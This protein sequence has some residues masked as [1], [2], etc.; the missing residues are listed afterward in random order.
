MR[1]AAPVIAPVVARLINFSFSSGSFA[2]RWKTA[3]VYPLSKNGDSR[4]VQNFRPT[5]HPASRASFVFFFTEEEKSRLCPN[6]V[7]SLKPP[8]PELL[9]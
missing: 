9:D 5:S 1:I 8:Q 3:K 6:R 2:S 7:N 4:D